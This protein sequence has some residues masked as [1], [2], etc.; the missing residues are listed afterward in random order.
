M[1]SDDEKSYGTIVVMVELIILSVGIL[2][3]IVFVKLYRALGMLKISRDQ[4][5]KDI[6]LPT[7]S[8]CIA[9]RDETHAM[10]QCL[11]RVVASEYPKLEVIVLDDGSRDNTSVLIKSFAHAGVR[12]VDGEPLPDGWLGKNYAQS[13]LAKE[14][15]GKY[16]FFMDVDTLIERHTISRAVSYMLRHEARM[17]SFIPIRDDGWQTSTLMTT[18]RHFW[19][20]IR[21]TPARPR[22]ASNA[23]LIERQLVLDQ[24]DTDETLPLS[25]L[26]ETRIA[27]K[28]AD[29]H[30]YRLAMSDTWLGIRYE[31]KWSSQ[32]ETSIRLLYPQCDA[33]VLQVLWL[34]LLMLVA[35]AP[36]VLVWWEPWALMP[37]IAQYGIAYYYLRK[38]WGRYRFAG[39][40]LVPFTIAQEITLLIVS[41]YRYKRGT[42]TWKGRPIQVINRKELLRR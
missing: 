40:L 30:Q 1:S 10:T 23:W 29:Q 27:R 16:V 35:V 4:S 36:Y 7:V 37:I 26:M 5:D 24:L 20:C 14:A 19:T 33:Y 31:K 8:V 18:M 2:D 38:A 39:A 9:A 32:I 28:L 21:F 11:E 42:V 22:A 25:M 13:L 34:V 41:T 15:S 12:F 3:I 6:E 17:A